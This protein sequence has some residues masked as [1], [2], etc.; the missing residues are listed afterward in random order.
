[1]RRALLLALTAACAATAQVEVRTGSA[2]SLQGLRIQRPLSCGDGYVITWVAANSRFECLAPSGG[3]GGSSS[4]SAITPGTNTGALV[5]GN[6]GS[7][8]VSGSGTI[9]ATSLGGAAA[10]SYAP[11]ASPVFTGAPSLPAASAIGGVAL[12]GLTGVAKLTSGV[13]GAASGSDFLATVGGSCDSNKVIN[14]AWQCASVATSVTTQIATSVN[15]AASTPVIMATGTIFTG[16]TTSTTQPY[17]KFEPSGT[18]SNSWNTAGTMLGINGPSGF[19]GSLIDLQT[20]ATSR[21]SVSGTGSVNAVVFGIT[22][23]ATA[24]M[25]ASGFGL[26]SSARINFSSIGN[27]Q[28]G[29]DTS[30]VRIAPAVLKV[31]NATAGF[32]RIALD[33]A[34]PA[35]AAE[36]CTAQTIWADSGFVYV[37]VASGDI[38]RAAIATW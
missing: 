21:F 13:P 15:G 37:C 5:I 22:G 29:F 12:S 17:V 28:A 19:T 14:G 6:G 26:G 8:T 23:G 36:A 11:L 20:N 38:R 32:G 33:N 24:A 18:T 2:T 25:S 27:S 10:S 4:F 9:N 35:G 7:L 3:G 30:L 1:M 34:T 16:G 31:A